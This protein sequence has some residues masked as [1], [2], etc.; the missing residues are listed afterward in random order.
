MEAGHL[1]FGVDYNH[2]RLCHSKWLISHVSGFHEKVFV[3]AG[4]GDSPN[5]AGQ[6]RIFPKIGNAHTY[7]YL[8]M[9][10]LVAIVEAGSSAGGEPVDLTAKYDVAQKPI[11]P[12][13]APP[14]K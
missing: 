13:N 3:I 2:E 1:R 11:A 7:E 10:G 6:H 14:M 5:G 9:T 12:R 8:P 4:P